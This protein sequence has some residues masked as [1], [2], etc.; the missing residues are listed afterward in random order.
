MK[1]ILTEIRQFFRR[2]RIY[3]FLSIAIVFFY[4]FLFA[5]HTML[6]PEIS[7]EG[8]SQ[9]QIESLLREVPQ[10][11][12]VIEK[13][14]SG[15]PWLSGSV[16]LMT[17]AFMGTFV[18]GVWW[19]L[20]DL[21][22]WVFLKK[23]LVP[24][25]GQSLRITWGVTEVVKVVILFF[26]SGILLSLILAVFK[27]FLGQQFDSSL[28]LMMH[29]LLLDTIAVFFMVSV[30]QKTG[31]G[32]GDL[33]FHF[34]KLELR[35]F[36]LGIRTYFVIF[37]IFVGILLILVYIASRF[38]Y[39]PPT[40][41]LAEMLLKKE[42]LSLWTVLFSLLVPCVIGPI[43]EEIFF[44][45]FFYPAMRKYWGIASTTVITAVLF[46]AVHQNIFSFLP[47]FFLGLVLC[48]LY[49]KR[50]SLLACISL[51]MLHNTAFLA[52]FFLMRSILFTR[53][54]M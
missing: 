9:T 42:T 29:T 16:Q 51:H 31:A 17:F 1:Q 41:P 18:C 20:S 47:I 19:G 46:A 6:K 35:E 8:Q 32:F 25:S 23:E 38:A 4:V 34:G 13:R 12:E 50:S 37:P 28:L 7:S 39:E 27:L 49:E 22:K 30:V 24:A 5:A 36:W 26:G 2:E 21:R 45:G 44:R 11:A 52:Y 3:L 33:G 40:H 53:E 43:V 15:R 54:G 10:K 48:Y 14:L